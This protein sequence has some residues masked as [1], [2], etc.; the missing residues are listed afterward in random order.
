[1]QQRAKKQIQAMKR[2]YQSGAAKQ[3]AKEQRRG[4]E[5]KG[6]QTL[7]DLGWQIHPS[8]SLSGP[9]SGSSSTPVADSEVFTE[10]LDDQAVPTESE[11]VED[12]IDEVPCK[13]SHSASG[14]H[15]MDDS[16]QSEQESSDTDNTNNGIYYWSWLL[17]TVFLYS[18]GTLQ[19]R[20]NY[21]S[22]CIT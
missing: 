14:E 7:E 5:A 15:K 12:E 17:H 16:S 21:A 10:Q 18:C 13:E 1:V 20:P 11:S 4:S 2:Q 8:A 19:F 9:S 3:K 22:T 6:K